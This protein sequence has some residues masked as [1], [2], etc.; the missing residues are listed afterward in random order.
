MTVGVM[1]G[2]MDGGISQQLNG[3]MDEGIDEEMYK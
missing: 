1:C 2:G 3:G